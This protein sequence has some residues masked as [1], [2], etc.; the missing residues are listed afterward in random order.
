MELEAPRSLPYTRCVTAEKTD[1]TS[2]SEQKKKLMSLLSS[3]TYLSTRYNLWW[4]PACEAGLLCPAYAPIPKE[5]PCDKHGPGSIHIVY[6][7]SLEYLNEFI[8]KRGMNVR[9]AE[10]EF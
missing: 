1:L 6:Q 4:C 5:W 10:V 8:A 2:A 7:E 3:D 9:E